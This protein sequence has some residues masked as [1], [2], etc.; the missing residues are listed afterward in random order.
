MR[1]ECIQKEVGLKVGK[2][3]QGWV[4][5]LEI[6]TTRA[7]VGASFEAKQW[8]PARREGEVVH[9]WGEWGERPSKED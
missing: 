2:G 5:R 1:G 9:E 8:N 7:A 3:G 6:V 4:A